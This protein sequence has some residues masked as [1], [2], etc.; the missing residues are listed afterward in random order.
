MRSAT[1]SALAALLASSIVSGR[2]FAFMPSGSDGLAR[3]LYRR[4]VT[5]V[6]SNNGTYAA[7]SMTDFASAPSLQVR[8]DAYLQAFVSPRNGNLCTLSVLIKKPASEA[9]ATLRLY[10]DTTPQISIVNGTAKEIAAAL[11]R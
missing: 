3:A 1:F 5:A 10:D 6:C 8:D 11:G 9:V 2:E 7:G 4:D